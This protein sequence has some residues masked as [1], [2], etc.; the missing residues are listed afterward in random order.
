MDCKTYIKRCCQTW[1]EHPPF[2]GCEGCEDPERLRWAVR[3][4]ARTDGAGLAGY[5]LDEVNKHISLFWNAYI[6]AFFSSHYMKL[7]G[8]FQAN[9]LYAWIREAKAEAESHGWDCAK[10]IERTDEPVITAPIEPEA[11]ANS[12]AVQ[13]PMFT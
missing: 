2:V 11:T 10:A 8:N 12:D 3:Y 9:E 6:K 1:I 4:Y 7:M 5:P 13:L